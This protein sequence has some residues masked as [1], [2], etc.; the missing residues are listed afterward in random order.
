MCQAL[1]LELGDNGSEEKDT[2]ACL[3]GAYILAWGDGQ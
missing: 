1:F 3:H 2:N